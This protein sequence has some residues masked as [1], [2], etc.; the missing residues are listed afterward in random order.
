MNEILF[1]IISY[2]VMAS[3]IAVAAY[4]LPLIRKWAAVAE[5]ELRDNN[6]ALAAQIV[7]DAVY[8][9]EQLVAG[10]GQGEIKFA[11][12]K[13]L[14]KTG[15]DQYGIAMTDEQITTM[16]EAVVGALN[17]KYIYEEEAEEDEYEV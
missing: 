5:T 11:E 2:L 9:V 10:S 1:Q 3:A 7:H 6:H 13:K 17:S 4:L 12:A 16:I 15:L 8:A 14:I